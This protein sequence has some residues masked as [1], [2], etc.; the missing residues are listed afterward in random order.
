M[1]NQRIFEIEGVWVDQKTIT[2]SFKPGGWINPR[3]V[4][5]FSKLKN[6]DQLDRGRKGLMR[7][8]EILEHILSIDDM[9][10]LY[11]EFVS[12]VFAFT[13]LIFHFLNY[14]CFSGNKHAG[15]TNEPNAKSLRSCK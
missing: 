2:L 3:V 11:F 8:S 14:Q 15:E 5:C 4:G 10:S 7:N 6:K 13:S 9:V 12:S 1:N